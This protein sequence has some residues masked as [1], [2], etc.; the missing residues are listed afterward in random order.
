VAAIRLRDWI[1]NEWLLILAGLVSVA[2][3]VWLIVQP[4]KGALAVLWMI[5]AYAI[6]YG[7]VIVI[8]A[9]RIRNFVGKVKREVRS[10]TS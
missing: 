5:S 10:A 4:D 3:G 1:E 2:F 7:L 8:L 9:F 6:V